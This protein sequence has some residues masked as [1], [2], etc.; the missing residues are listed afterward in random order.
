MGEATS[1]GG[2]ALI[3][4]DALRAAGGYRADLIAGEEPEL[5]LRLRRAGWS[6][7][8]IDAE[9]TWHDAAIHRFAQWWT[10][11]VRS[12]HAYGE[13]AWLHGRSTD[14]HWV[15]ENVRALALVHRNTCLGTDA[16]PV[17]GPLGLAA[18]EPVSTASGPDVDPFGLTG[19]SL[20]FDIEPFCGNSGHLAI[21]CR[22]LARPGRLPHRIQVRRGGTLPDQAPPPNDPLASP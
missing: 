16:E 22:P 7:W 14:R 3:R 15:K 11:S 20:A 18:S 10:R 4:C 2:D 12:G 13:G 1:C 21:S 17:Q 9:M 5:C 8:R 19:R 6:I